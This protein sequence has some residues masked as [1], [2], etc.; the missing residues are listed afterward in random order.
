MNHIKI[1]RLMIPCIKA[2]YKE[3]QTQEKFKEY[4][5]KQIPKI[6]SS[7]QSTLNS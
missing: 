3:T 4:I 1:A 7:L 2:T 5:R 6:S